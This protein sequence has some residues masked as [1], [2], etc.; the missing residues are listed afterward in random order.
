[1]SPVTECFG[2]Q[3]PKVLA[4]TKDARVIFCSTSRRLLTKGVCLHT[5]RLPFSLSFGEL[6]I[7]DGPSKQLSSRCVRLMGRWVNQSAES[8]SQPLLARREL[9]LRRWCRRP[10]RPSSNGCDPDVLVRQQ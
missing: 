3:S 1:M 9:S 5:R 2:G 7:I 6:R 8:K 4:S 10:R